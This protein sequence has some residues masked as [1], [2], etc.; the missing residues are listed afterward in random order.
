VEPGI[1]RE[2]ELPHRIREPAGVPAG[3]LVLLHGRATSEEDLF[4]IL[5]ALD[6]ERRLLGVTP[7]G[8]LTGIPPGG[9]HWYVIEEVGQPD[10]QTFVDT[11]NQ[12]CRFLDD[13]LRRRGIEWENTV[14]GGFSQGGAVS[15]AAA[16]GTGRPRA[17]GVLAMSCFLPM[18]RGWR[19]DIRAKRGMQAYLSH[20][21]YDN[22]IPVGFGRRVRDLLVEGGVETHFRETRVQ[23]QI[24]PELIPE[25]RTWV[26]A[27][28]GGPDP[29]RDGPKSEI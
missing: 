24:D 27:R 20:G 1:A 10:E 15:L 3:A 13:L 12:L 25:M 7:G 9:R 29:L 6:P 11:M 26:G 18:V 19:I 14:I 5:D 2:A 21:T 8:P 22:I 16:F 17:A 4:P 28:T 23:H